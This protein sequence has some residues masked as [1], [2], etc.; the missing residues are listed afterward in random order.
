MILK[1]IGTAAMTVL[2][3]LFAS[4]GVLVLELDSSWPFLLVASVY[5]IVVTLIFARMVRELW[6]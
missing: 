6:S 2:G 3:L 5:W 4:A 1:I